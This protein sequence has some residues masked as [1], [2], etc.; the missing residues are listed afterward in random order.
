LHEFTIFFAE[1]LKDDDSFVDVP[2]ASWFNERLQLCL[3]HT[4]FEASILMSASLEEM[5]VSFPSPAT[6][7]PHNVASTSFSR[8]RLQ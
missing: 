5:R 1:S 8:V 4:L 7:V 3:R 6:N 2:S